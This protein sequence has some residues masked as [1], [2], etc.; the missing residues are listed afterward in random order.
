MSDTF[1]GSKRIQNGLLFTGLALMLISFSRNLFK[2]LMNDE[3]AYFSLAE[4]ML[5]T[6]S[7]HIGGAPSSLPPV[8][9]LWIYILYIPS[10]PDSTVL[11]VKV[12][13][14]VLILLSIVL[15][16]YLFCREFKVPKSIFFLIAGLF[17]FN[18]YTVSLASMLYAEAMIFFLLAAMVLLAVKLARNFGLNFFGLLVFSVSL[19]SLTK[20]NYLVLFALFPVIY[21]LHKSF[22]RRNP[23]HL[24]SGFFLLVVGLL[25]VFG[26]WKYTIH[27]QD[28]MN[29]TSSS[30]S[31][32]TENSFGPLVVDGFLS[33]NKLVSLF[34]PIEDFKSWAGSILILLL[35]LG[36]WGVKARGDKRA[37]VVLLIIVLIF[38]SIIIGGTG[39]SRYWLPLFPFMVFGMVVACSAILKVSLQKLYY[40]LMVILIIYCLN[41]VRLF[42]LFSYW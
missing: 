20:M 40:P 42:V 34:V 19:L 28:V 2:P 32:F 26:W 11:L 30:Y 22:F 15:F 5:F 24:V 14:W 9:P 29:I 18:P 13:N 35:A 12:F 31:R 27:I 7:Y 3:I 36:G 17:C 1:A 41:E 21:W 10:C 37:F 4:S 6:G 39:M 23:K 33:L 16:Y 38:G 25:P 8:Y